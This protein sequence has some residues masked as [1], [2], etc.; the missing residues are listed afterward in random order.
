MFALPLAK[1]LRENHEE[2]VR[3]WLESLH[4]RIADEFEQMLKTPMGGG[5]AHKLLGG[6]I[7]FLEAEEYQKAEVLRRVRDTASDAAFRRAA[8]GFNLSDIVATALAFRVALQDTFLSHSLHGG[9]EDERTVIESLLALNRLGDVLVLGEIAG[10]FN[11]HDFRKTASD[12]E[13]A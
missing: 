4:G 7:E 6:A 9:I 3:R 13:F 1:C 11:Y 8:V 2:V 10:Y 12:E 5:V